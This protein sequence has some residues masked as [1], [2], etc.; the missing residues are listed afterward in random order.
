MII[1][2][3]IDDTIAKTNDKLIEEAIKYDKEQLKGKGFKN[4]NA[5]SFME[6]FYWSVVDVD[7]FLDY[8][9]NSKFF[10]EVE[11]INDASLY[12]NKL[13]DMGCKIV[14]ITRRRDSFKVKSRTKKWLKNHGFKYHKLILGAKNKGKICNELGV[15][16]FVDNDIKNVYDAMDF[17]IDSIVMMDE[18]NK[19]ENELK[20]VSSWDEVYNYVCGVMKDGQNS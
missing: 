17:G 5:Y 1:G 8:I 16:L 10:L 4:R 11:P 6:M 3:D 9:R 19:D 12:I 14:F 20:V 13:Y 18:Y 7:S 15:S 2:I